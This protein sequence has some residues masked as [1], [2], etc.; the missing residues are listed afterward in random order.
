MNRITISDALK[1]QFDGIDVPVEVV[2]A[3]GHRL[4]HFVPAT[5]LPRDECPYSAE[6]LDRMQHEPGGRSLTEIW[7]ALGAK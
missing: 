3:A 1:S 5:V 4:G 6:E 2:D 7:K